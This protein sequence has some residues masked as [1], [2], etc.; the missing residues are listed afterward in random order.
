MKSLELNR[1][2]LAIGA[3]AALLAGC[4]GSQ[5]PIAAP[6]V[7][8]QNHAINVTMATQHETF[9]YTGA[10]QSFKVPAAVTR[11]D[12]DARGAAGT[13]HKPGYI[14]S[15]GN[16]GRV[17][18][19]IPVQAGQTL[20]V[21]VG[22]K[23]SG[24]T[25]G[26]NGGGNGGGGSACS[27]GSGGGGAS[28]VRQHGDTLSDRI[29]VAGAGGGVGSN[30][31]SGAINGGGGG[32]KKGGNGENGASPG[33]G[34][35]GE[36]GS[37]SKGGAGGH[38]GAARHG[39][40]HRGHAGVLGIGGNGGTCGYTRYVGGS[41]GGG[42]G[43]YYGGGAGGGGS[44]LEQGGGGGG[45]SSYVESSATNVHFVRGWKKATGNGLV[46]FSW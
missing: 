17:T 24:E 11:I 38:A 2:A 45:G 41:G 8:V 34:G 5:P 9:N 40:G 12:V 23:G 22:G 35:G 36:G 43:G 32:G 31:G 27:Y 10:E 42:G 33:G 13:G 29:L 7:M 14:G 46:V 26:F 18:A 21:F 20:D 6:G 19:T 16:G 3:A 28:D 37:Q 4:G 39:H 25:G 15:P 44:Y 1:Y 30:F